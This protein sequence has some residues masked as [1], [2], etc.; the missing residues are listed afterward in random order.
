MI[1]YLSG[2]SKTFILVAAYATIAILGA[3]DDLTGMSIP[4]DSPSAP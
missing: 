2:K 3:I 1:D 4:F